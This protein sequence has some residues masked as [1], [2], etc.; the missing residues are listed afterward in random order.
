VKKKVEICVDSIESAIVAAKAGA[1]RIELCRN[2][3][4]G[5]TTPNLGLLK[6]IKREIDIPVHVLIRPR[7]GD[8]VYSEFEKQEILIDIADFIEA[9]VNG[10]VTGCL[11]LDGT[12][13]I[14]F[15]KRIKEASQKV[16]LT[17]HRAFDVCLD[18]FESL[19]VLV[20]NEIE[21]LLTSGAKE[22]ALK[23]AELIKELISVAEGKIT[24]IAASGVREHNVR[25]L[26]E[27]TRVDEIHAT[28]FAKVYSGY[29]VTPDCK[30]GKDDQ[31]CYIHRT[32][33]QKVKNLIDEFKRY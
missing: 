5:G 17:F 27:I 32:D 10:I 31:L 28:A 30:M 22:T 3:L 23:G 12:I 21:Y 24:I 6:M 15:L 33:F 7:A 20:D 1:D 26:F 9:G 16:P 19:Q 8:F 13:D 4:Q 11:K 29:Q 18:P 14:A 2:I 25:K